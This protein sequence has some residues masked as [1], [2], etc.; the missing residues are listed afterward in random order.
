[1]TENYFKQIYKE[2]YKKLLH[3]SVG[4]IG[5]FYAED[6]VSEVFADFWKS[7]GLPSNFTSNEEAFLVIR[8]KYKCYEVLL[9]KRNSKKERRD[10]KEGTKFPYRM[11][12]EIRPDVKEHLSNDAFSEEFADYL[13]IKA[14]LI[15]LLASKVEKFP[16][17]KKKVFDLLFLEGLKPAEI[18]EKEGLHKNAISNQKTSILKDL[19]A[20]GCQIINPDKRWVI[21]DNIRQLSK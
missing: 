20:F 1:M 7:G 9:H 11:A 10:K 15:K 14:D 6:I 19:F 8:L 17:V 18:I 4:L 2:S 21:T 5:E 12:N 16:K 13:V 3:I